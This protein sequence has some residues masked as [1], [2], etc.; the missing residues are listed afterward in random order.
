MRRVQD[1]FYDLF[2]LERECHDK[3]YEQFSFTPKNSGVEYT[4]NAKAID[5]TGIRYF[6]E[7]NGFEEDGIR[8]M[9]KELQ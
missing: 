8:T 7:D 4:Y 9:Y 3:L 1:L 6:H 2:E 5:T